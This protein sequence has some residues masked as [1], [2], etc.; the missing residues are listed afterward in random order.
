MT[1]QD[2]LQQKL[3]STPLPELLSLYDTLTNKQR[4]LKVM[5]KLAKLDLYYLMVVICNRT[6]LLACANPQWV[7]DRAREVQTNPDGYLDLWAREH[8]KSSLITFGLTLQ[9]ILK[10]PSITIGFISEKYTIAA[11][12]LGQL[13]MEMETNALLKKLFPEILY[14]NP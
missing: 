11:D 2:P 9:D 14:E 10:N 7:L 1:K 5:R 6:D 13:K 12:F 8:Y 3:F 4:D